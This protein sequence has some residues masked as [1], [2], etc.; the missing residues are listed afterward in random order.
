MCKNS[1]DFC[2][3]ILYPATL[4]NLFSNSNSY[5]MES[6]GFSI[7]NMSS[8]YTDNFTSSFPICMPFISFSSL[9]A[10]ARTLNTMLNKSGD[11]RYPCL[12]PDL[13]GK[14]SLALGLSYTTFI[15]LQYVPSILSL[16]RLFTINGC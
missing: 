3:L 2:A 13:R 1:T 9:N 10:L 15:M 14:V 12:V 6:L 16:L 11:S 7:H 8:A 4:L 5:L